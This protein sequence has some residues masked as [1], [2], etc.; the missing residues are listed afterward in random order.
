MTNSIGL[1][2]IDIFQISGAISLQGITFFLFAVVRPL[3]FGA[4]FGL[5]SKFGFAHYG[6]LLGVSQVC[7]GLANQWQ[8]LLLFLSIP[9]DTAQAM[10]TQVSFLAA[11]IIF[12]CMSVIGLAFPFFVRKRIEISG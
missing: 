8:F 5:F 10:G 2:L 3:H 6:K 1:L 4:L 7:I 9:S 11:N 12:V